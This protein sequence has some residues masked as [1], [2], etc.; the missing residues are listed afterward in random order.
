MRQVL[1]V[2]FAANLV[3]ALVKG[4]YGLLTGSLG[5]VADGVHSLL[6]SLGSIVGLVGV[7][8]AGRPP[9]PSHPYGYERY[10]PLAALGIVALMFLAAREILG[11]AWSRLSTGVVP[12][13]TPLSFLLMGLAT[14][15]TLALALWEERRGR[16]LRSR[17]LRADGRRAL[18]D[19][20]VS[21]SVII[22]F[23]ATLW[24]LP[25]ADL[26]VSVGIVAIIGWTGWTQLRELSAILTDAA[27]ADLDQIARAAQSVEGVLGVHRVRARGAAGSVRVDLHVTV[28]PMLPTIK[29]HELTHQVVAQVQRELKGI[30]EVLVHVGVEPEPDHGENERH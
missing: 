20:L 25:L 7:T 3:L 26:V 23:V 21:F 11:T 17:V 15:A 1:L 18:S 12:A 4:G 8:L 28:D 30:T 10:E 22:G 9:D 14:A 29:A 19:V 6:H 24:G 5:M 13:I 27:V 16:A 2:T